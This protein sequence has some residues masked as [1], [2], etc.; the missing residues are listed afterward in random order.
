MASDYERCL[1][2]LKQIK[3]KVEYDYKVNR[4]LHCDFYGLSI[5]NHILIERKTSI[6]DLQKGIWQ[7]LKY[8][9]ELTKLKVFSKYKKPTR[10]FIWFDL[11]KK[12]PNRNI[13]KYFRT[14]VDVYEKYI[15]NP[16]MP[17]IEFCYGYRKLSKNYIIAHKR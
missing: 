4:W 12:L 6:S 1:S 11:T 13:I 7:I 5:K 17:N 10:L 9:D 2:F 15:K 14:L 3:I 16:N 8:Y